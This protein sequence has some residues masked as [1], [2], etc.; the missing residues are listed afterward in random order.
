MKKRA[1]IVTTIAICLGF[2]LQSLASANVPSAGGMPSEP[3]V[4]MEGSIVQH[5]ADS[6]TMRDSTGS[7]QTIR[8]TNITKI[9]ERKSNPFRGARKYSQTDLIPGLHVQVEGRKDSSNSLLAEK[10][11]FSDQDLIVARTVE[12]RVVPVEKRVG[13]TETRVGQ[14]EQSAQRLSDEV[15]ELNEVSNILRGGAKAAQDTADSAVAGV[16][17]TN[18]RIS[19]LDDFEERKSVTIHFKAGSTVLTPEAKTDLDEIAK[20]AKV[21]RGYVIE[22]A[23]FASSDGNEQLNRTLSQARADAVVHYLAEDHMVPMRRI[24]TP[25]GYGVIRPVADNQTREGRK[26]NRRVEVR[27]LVS[28]GLNAPAGGSTTARTGDQ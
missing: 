10:I 28:R 18:E 19:A 1:Q 13:D 25:L 16:N 20:T 27:V 26:M 6:I 9:E 21:E 15:A 12:T 2:A 17:Q 14:T 5:G 8:I 11:R 24:V 7:E 22:V 3:K 4:K 23:G